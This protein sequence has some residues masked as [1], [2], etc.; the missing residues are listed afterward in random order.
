MATTKPTPGQTN[1]SGVVEPE[2]P[3]VN[4]GIKADTTSGHSYLDGNGASPGKTNV[5]GVNDTR[6]APTFKHNQNIGTF[7]APIGADEE[8]SAFHR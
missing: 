7:S 8:Q 4:P 1:V 2:S 5:T 6:G 3:A